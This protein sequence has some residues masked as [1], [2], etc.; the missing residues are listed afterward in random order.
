MVWGIWKSRIVKV[1][2]KDGLRTALASV[3]PKPP[4]K[5]PFQLSP[6]DWQ[7]ASPV[8]SV[9]NETLDLPGWAIH[10]SWGALSQVPYP[11]LLPNRSNRLWRPGQ[12]LQPQWFLPWWVALLLWAQVSK[13]WW[14]EGTR[15]LGRVVRRDNQGSPPTILVSPLPTVGFGPGDRSHLDSPEAREAMFL[16]RAGSSWARKPTFNQ[17]LVF[18]LLKPLAWFIAL[19]HTVHFIPTLMLLSSS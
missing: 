15:G 17:T 8:H 18:Q 16:R 19:T 5:L 3:I 13:V 11:N 1:A 7:I 6:K 9:K 14:H 4:W 2:A 12:L 10:G